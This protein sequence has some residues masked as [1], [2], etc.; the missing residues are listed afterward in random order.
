M[1]HF[2]INLEASNHSNPSKHYCFHMFLLCQPG[3]ILD[4]FWMPKAPKMNPMGSKMSPRDLQ[5]AP[6]TPQMEPK[7]IK[8]KPRGVQSEPEAL[9]VSPRTSK[10]SQKAPKVSSKSPQGHQ[11]A[12][13]TRRIAP[14]NSKQ[15]FHYF[16][17]S[18]FRETVLKHCSK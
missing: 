11:T 10:V 18:L 12:H 9:T 15:H 17:Q 1:M 8:V 2:S 3:V 4:E 5:G 7:G 16:S 6:K 14:Q 13:K